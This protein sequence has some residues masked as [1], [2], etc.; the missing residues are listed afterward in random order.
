MKAIRTFHPATRAIFVIFLAGLCTTSCCI[1]NT[2]IAGG[3]GV[4]TGKIEIVTD[5]DFCSPLEKAIYYELKRCSDR[6]EERWKACGPT[7]ELDKSE[8]PAKPV[9]PVQIAKCR[10]GHYD[11]YQKTFK[12]LVALLKEADPTKGRVEQDEIL[13][14]ARNVADAYIALN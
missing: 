10:Q 3:Y 9:D 11:E 6:Y 12:E 2:K 8:E 7:K 1:T 4:Y 5:F 13:T 14:K